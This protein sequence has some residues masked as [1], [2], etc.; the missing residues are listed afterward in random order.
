MEQTIEQKFVTY[1]FERH[2]GR[3]DQG[4]TSEFATSIIE[5]M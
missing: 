1:D 5:N 3:R 4:E 2:D